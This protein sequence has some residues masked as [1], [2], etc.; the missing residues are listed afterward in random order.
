MLKTLK[1][2]CG[3]YILSLLFSVSIYATCTPSSTMGDDSIT[4]T[5]TIDGTFALDAQGGSDIVTLNSVSGNGVYWLDKATGGELATDGNDTFIT[6]NSTFFWVFTFRGDDKIEIY[7]SNFSNA[8]ADTN[9]EW[10]GAYPDNR[11]AQR[12]NDSIYVENSISDGWITGG[13][14]SDYM[15]IKDSQVSYVASGY[16]DIYSDI[17]GYFDFTPFDSNDTIVLD[18]V[19]FNASSYAY[20]NRP[21]AVDG[22]KDNDIIIFKNGGSAYNVVGGH[23][24]DHIVLDDAVLFTP[25]NFENDRGAN[26]ECGIYG[27]VPYESEANTTTIAKHGNDIIEIKN[28]NISGV[29]VNAGHGSDWVQINT[30]TIVDLTIFDGGDDRNSTDTFIDKLV[31]DAWHGDLNGSNLKNWESIVFDNSTEV[32]FLDNT[33]LTGFESGIDPVTNLPYGLII[34]NDSSLKQ[35]QHFT[36]DGN[37]YNNAN[38]HLQNSDAA[39]TVLTIN[40]DYNSTG[41]LY[42]DTVLNDASFTISDQLVVKG[43]TAGETRIYVDNIGGSGGLTPRASNSGILL[44][45]VDGASNGTFVLAHSLEVGDYYYFLKKGDNG[46]WYLRSEIPPVAPEIKSIDDNTSTNI[47]TKNNR[48]EING[49][50]EA[51]NT[52]IIQ[53][54]G[55]DIEPTTVCTSEG[56]F[57]IIPAIALD[58]GEHNVTVKQKSDNNVSSP[59]SSTDT[60]HIN[61]T[62][63]D[64]RPTL[65]AEGTIIVGTDG[66]LDLVIRIGEFDGGINFD[67]DLKFTIVKNVNLELTFDSTKVMQQGEI[68]H[69][70]LWT[71]TQTNALYIF[72]YIAN[73]K[74]FPASTVSRIGL[75]GTFTSPS[76]VKG[77]FALDV[78]IVGGTG[79]ENL[80]NNKDTD[81]L[82]YNNLSN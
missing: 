29:T 58:D 63:P 34:K 53:I 44:I 82:E 4:C 7:D 35:Y 42:L 36:I 66:V 71:M 23:G 33:L 11:V 20:A 41:S 27:D 73:S 55:T 1:Y 50:C 17:D 16:S 77:Q 30:P 19:I 48:P 9:P 8:Y 21:G 57:S 76:R 3:I 47:F 13:N 72:T 24:N 14:D 68:I 15:L 60:V 80:G 6:H 45:K 74:M 56:I 37:L 5:D 69:N 51:N 67:A 79:E 46:N 38:V 32:S 59:V 54:D 64:Y 25:C 10:T 43:N 2:I 65:Y 49:T 62:L 12:G 26:V 52:V 18:N 75:S 40:N 22:G 70:P 31:F 78:T 28:A 39:G 81:V 61:T